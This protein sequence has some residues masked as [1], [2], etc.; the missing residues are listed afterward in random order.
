MCPFLLDLVSDHPTC[1]GLK[2]SLS[3]SFSRFCGWTGLSWAALLLPAMLH[4]ITRAGRP[5]WPALLAGAGSPA[6]SLDQSTSVLLPVPSLHGLCLNERCL[7]PKRREIGASSL[8][9]TWAQMSRTI[10]LLPRAVRWPAVLDGGLPCAS[11]VLALSRPSLELMSGLWV[12][13]HWRRPTLVT[14][15]SGL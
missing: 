12:D 3:S 14:V 4:C 15:G 8:C 10:V 7:D 5:G 11:R 9:R 13:W 2:Q 1:S 6:E